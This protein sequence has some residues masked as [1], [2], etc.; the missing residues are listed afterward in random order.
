MHVT[1]LPLHLPMGLGPVQLPSLSPAAGV[2][3]SS[4]ALGSEGSAPSG[5][6]SFRGVWTFMS[7]NLSDGVP[8]GLTRLQREQ[9]C[10][11]P[12]LHVLWVSSRGSPK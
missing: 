11:P 2:H 5:G 4:Q 1:S 3:S 9:H 12:S 8:G 7:H 6:F 10:F